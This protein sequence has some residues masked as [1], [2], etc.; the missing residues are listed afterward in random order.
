MPGAVVE[1][2]RHEGLEESL[3]EEWDEFVAGC[4]GG[5]HEQTSLWGQLKQLYGWQPVRIL[6]RSEGRI[7][8]GAQILVKEVRGPVR[9]GYVCKG[10]LPAD[11]DPRAAARLWN[12]IRAFGQKNRLTSLTAE[13]P[14]GG[15]TLVPGCRAAGFVPHPRYL[16]PSGLMEATLILDL[17]PAPETLL[18][19]MRAR[20]RYNIRHA[21]RKGVVVREGAEQDVET[22]RSLMW[23]LCERLG[24][25][26]TPPEKDFFSNLWKV[27]A[28]G[29]GV[30]LFVAE[31]GGEAVSACLTFP[32]GDCVRL[33]KV[34]WSGKHR[35]CHPNYALWWEAIQWARRAGYRYFDFVWIDAES[36]KAALAG[37]PVPDTPYG[38]MAFYKLGFGGQIVLLPG[39]YTLFT[40]PILRQAAGVGAFKLLEVPWLRRMV[41][42]THRPGTS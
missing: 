14:A 27:F 36:A 31:V 26:P 7:C 15:H 4:P 42:H 17:A 8:A 41:S 24:S 12:E 19:N 25:S 30:K 3:N 10:P 5:H 13:L 28:P 37:A 2:L 20:T 40:N 16:P 35:E 9:V 1:P 23:Q 22:F 38:Q 33:W 39:A 6:Q 32:F 11:L 18:E 29:G 21:G 34:G